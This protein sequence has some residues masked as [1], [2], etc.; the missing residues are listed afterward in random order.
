MANFAALF[1]LLPAVLF[2]LL[3]LFGIEE[4]TNMLSLSSQ[5]LAGF[6]L[7]ALCFAAFFLFATVSVA[8]AIA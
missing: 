5:P 3:G 4:L 1:L 8:G 7:S 2:G 6:A